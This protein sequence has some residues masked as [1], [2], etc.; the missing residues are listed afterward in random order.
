MFYAHS[1]ILML[2]SAYSSAVNL[3]LSLKDCSDEVDEELQPNY[4]ELIVSDWFSSVS[5]P[6]D[7][8]SFRICSNFLTKYLHMPGMKNWIHAREI[9]SDISR[10]HKIFGL[11][12]FEII[13]GFISET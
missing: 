4:K 13:I 2:Y 10:E 5:L 1:E 7:K 6:M 11:I 9:L 12:T 8:A 3:N